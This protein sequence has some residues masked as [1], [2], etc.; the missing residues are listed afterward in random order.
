LTTAPATDPEKPTLP[1][2]NERE[3][4]ERTSDIV[5][6]EAA[7]V[8]KAE[9]AALVWNRTTLLAIYAWY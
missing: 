7:G 5:N 8:K 4:D 1:T 9:A 3:P 6:G 2:A